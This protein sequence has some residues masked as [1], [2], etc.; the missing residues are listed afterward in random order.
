M[1]FGNEIVRLAKGPVNVAKDKSLKGTRGNPVPDA[2]GC[3][4]APISVSIC[5]P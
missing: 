3:W 1:S 5:K 4:Q 2:C